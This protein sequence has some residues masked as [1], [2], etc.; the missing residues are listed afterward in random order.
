MAARQQW[1]ETIR[2]SIQQEHGKGWSVREIGATKRKPIGR[3]QLTRILEDRTRSSVIPPLEWRLRRCRGGGG[4]MAR[5]K[6][7][8]L[9][10]ATAAAGM[11]AAEASDIAQMLE[12]LDGML[13]RLRLGAIREQ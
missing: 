11:P 4:L 1:Y 8:A 13:G 5:N 12:D 7:L 9:T 2:L 3:C 10:I 6:P